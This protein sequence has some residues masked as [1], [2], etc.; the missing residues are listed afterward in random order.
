MHVEPRFRRQIKALITKDPSAR[1]LNDALSEADRIRF[2]RYGE[3]VVAV[4]LRPRFGDATAADLTALTTAIVA[5]HRVERRPVNALVIEHV[6][7]AAFGLP[8]LFDT[9]EVPAYIVSGS[10][11]AVIRHERDTRP[12]VARKADAILDAAEAALRT[13][14]G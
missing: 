11:A 8:S 3:A 7:L 6:L 14:T 1:A 4:L 13:Q 5:G 10:A 9:A 12:D 2:N